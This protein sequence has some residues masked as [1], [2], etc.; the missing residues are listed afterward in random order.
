LTLFPLANVVLFS[1]AYWMMEITTQMHTEKERDKIQLTK[2]AF[3]FYSLSCEGLSHFTC[4]LQQ[5]TLQEFLAI[6]KC[7]RKLMHGPCWSPAVRACV[8]V[9]VCVCVAV[10]KPQ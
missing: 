9:C 1:G 2:N 10:M 4:N 6:L 7:D 8:C 5:C 3:S